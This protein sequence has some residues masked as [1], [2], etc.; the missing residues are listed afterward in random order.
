M[1]K[2]V[3]S[4]IANKLGPMREVD[5]EKGG[6]IWGSLIRIRVVID[7]TKPLKRAL[8]IRTFIGDE[9]LATFTYK[10]L[11]N[12]CYFCGCMDHIS[13]PCELQ[14]KQ[15]FVDPGEN[16]PFGAWLRAPPPSASRGRAPNAGWRGLYI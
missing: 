6:A 13:R 2:E 15:D 10:R 8:K 7:V 5:Q 12:F 11:Q 1:N 14:F 16:T 4:F 9:Q 3:A